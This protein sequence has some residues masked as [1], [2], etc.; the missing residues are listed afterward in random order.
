MG[1][2]KSS[3]STTDITTTTTA[4]IAD[5]FNQTLSDIKS[6]T[7]SGNVSVGGESTMSIVV[8][9]AGLA[10]VAAVVLYFVKR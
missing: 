4:N 2:S 9:L 6:F 8:V 1:S 3:S 10:G 7:N 5:S